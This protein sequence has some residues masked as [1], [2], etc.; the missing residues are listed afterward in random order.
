[1]RRHLF[2]GGA[3][4]AAAVIAAVLAGYGSHHQAYGG[5]QSATISTDELHRQVDAAALPIMQVEEPY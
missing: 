4:V 5:G 1:M 3:I 2:V